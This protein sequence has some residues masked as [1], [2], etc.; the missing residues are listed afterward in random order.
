MLDYSTYCDLSPKP[1]GEGDFDKFILLAKNKYLFFVGKAIG[2][3]NEKLVL[4]QFVDIISANQNL[5]IEYNSYSNGVESVSY[6]DS[7]EQALNKRL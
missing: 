6:K 7:S 1:L 4:T 5:N 2:G 3:D